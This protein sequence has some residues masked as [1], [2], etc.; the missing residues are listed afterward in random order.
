MDGLKDHLILHL[1]EKSTTK[2][3][4]DMLKNLYEAKNKSRKMELKDKLHGTRMAK[5][6]SVASC[7]LP[8]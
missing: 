5:G 4:W 3:M 7:L 1:A 2:E 6:E 8:H